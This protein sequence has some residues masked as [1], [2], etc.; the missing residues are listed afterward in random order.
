M[1]VAEFVLK[2]LRFYLCVDTCAYSETECRHHAKDNSQK[3]IAIHQ[4]KNTKQT[5]INAYSRITP[6]KASLVIAEIRYKYRGE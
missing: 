6:E 3:L 4:E 2:R 1:Y 5:N